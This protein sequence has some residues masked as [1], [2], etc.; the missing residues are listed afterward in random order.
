MGGGVSLGTFSGAALSEAIKQQIV[1]G[2]YDTGKKDPNGKAIL[3][4]FEKITIDLFS[5]ASAGAVSLAIMLRILVNPKDK[6]HLLGYRSYPKMRTDLEQKLAQQFGSILI[7]FKKEYPEKYEQLIAA[8]TIQEFQELIW[9]KKVNVDRFLGTG[10][11]EKN[12]SDHAGFFDRSVIEELARDVFQFQTRSARLTNRVLL[13]DRV[14]FACTLANLSHTLKSSKRTHLS[15]TKK[16]SLIKALNDSSVDRI[17]SELRVF[18]LNF[19]TIHPSDHASFPLKWVQYHDA[20]NLLLVQKDGEGNSYNKIIENLNSNNVWREITATAIASS[21][22]PFAFEPVVLNRY[23]FEYGSSWSKELSGKESYPFTYVDGGIFNNEPVKDAFRLASFMDHSL[24]DK[25]FERQL[26]FVD[27]D[28]S[29]LENHFKIQAHEKLSVGRSIFS[30]KAKVSQKPPIIRILS[31]MTHILSA[32]LN[33]AQSIEVGKITSLLEKFEHR[34]HHRRLLQNCIQHTCSEE[35]LNES[36]KFLKHELNKIREKLNLPLNALSLENEFR[37][38]VHEDTAYLKT[39]LPEAPKDIDEAIHK[40]LLAK[41]KSK[42][43]YLKAWLYILNCISL[44]VS[45]NLIAKTSQAKLIPIAPF[46]FY[47][48]DEQYELM[49]LPGNGL[50]GFSGFASEAASNYE[51]AY[52]KF[53]ANKIMEELELIAPNNQILPCP[54]PFDYSCYNVDIRTDLKNSIVKRF[55]EMLPYSVAKILPFLDGYLNESIQSFVDKNIN[56][57]SKISYFEFRIKVNN[58]R[59]SLRGFDEEGNKAHSKSIHPIQIHGDYFLITKLLFDFDEHQWM[60]TQTKYMQSFYLDKIKFFDDIPSV[61]IELPIMN[62]HSEAY[63]SPNPIFIADA[64]AAL[65][66]EKMI[67]LN[68]ACWELINEIAPLDEHLWGIDRWLE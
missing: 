43:T 10:A 34:D 7:D 9:S 22:F 46:N 12:M 62:V 66:T 17:H 58:D 6:F 65:N 30:S 5:G 36:I 35:Q 57:N 28:V 8:Q 61:S 13:G 14:L 16:P 20:S 41:N 32:I 55:K 44:D 67:D 27:P 42:D 19:K 15:D 56:G 59:F 64:T 45:L 21:A 68:A 53:C 39:M 47:N 4:P 18:D 33:E 40:F 37:R 52:G 24:E 23:R 29:D 60:G 25:N 51:V 31:G 11:F 1:Y 50:A 49:S 54:P 2:Q 63:L 48:I 38:I 3:K 26:I